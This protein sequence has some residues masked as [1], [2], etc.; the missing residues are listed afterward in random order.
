MIQIR[1]MM[2][3][4]LGKNTVLISISLTVNVVLVIVV[5]RMIGLLGMRIGTKRKKSSFVP[6]NPKIAK[7]KDF[8]FCLNMTFNGPVEFKQ[9]I[10]EYAIVG[11][12]PVYYSRNTNTKIIHFIFFC[13]YH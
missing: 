3:K 1:R 7:K 4:G 2:Y 10:K 9:V 8:D 12:F 6:Y 11:G 5:K 13:F